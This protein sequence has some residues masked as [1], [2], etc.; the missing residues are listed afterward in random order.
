MY[1]APDASRSDMRK[2]SVLTSPIYSCCEQLA[3]HSTSRSPEIAQP[4]LRERAAVRQQPAF[5]EARRW[6]FNRQR[7]LNCIVERR[8][9]A[10]VGTDLSQLCAKHGSAFQ[11]AVLCGWNFPVSSSKVIIHSTAR[12]NDTACFNHVCSAPRHEIILSDF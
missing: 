5:S 6:N 12:G 8:A 2:Q 4:L 3:L 10:C 1:V 11:L 9:G 7:G